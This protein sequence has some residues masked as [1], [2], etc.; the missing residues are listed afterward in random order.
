MFLCKVSI[1]C[2]WQHRETDRR[3]RRRAENRPTSSECTRAFIDIK[4]TVTRNTTAS[5]CSV[6]TNQPNKTASAG[7]KDKWE[8][9]E[10]HH[11]LRK[12]EGCINCYIN[13]MTLDR[14]LPKSFHRAALS[15]WAWK[16]EE[17]WACQNVTPK[18][19]TFY[20]NTYI[21]LRQGYLNIYTEA[22]NHI[23]S[24]H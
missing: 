19:S 1:Q 12:R 4:E 18:G 14:C 6:C 20:M 22:Y 24:S 5:T 9:S 17:L 23:T 13:H 11:N 16:W 8:H 7:K 2:M 21:K 15:I 10:V 3:K